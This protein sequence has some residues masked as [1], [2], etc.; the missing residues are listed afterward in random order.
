[1]RSSQ[2]SYSGLLHAAIIVL[3]LPA[4][5]AAQ[6][7]YAAQ[8]EGYLDELEARFVGDG[9]NL[10]GASSGW[11]I[12]GAEGGTLIRL[13][14]GSYVALGA[15]D[16]DCS[17]LELS[18]SG[19]DGETE[20]GADRAADAFPVVEF[21][22]AEAAT[23]LIKVSM[24]GCDTP[25][26]FTGYRWYSGEV[27]GWEEQIALQMRAL[28]TPEDASVTDERTGLVGAG[29]VIRFSLGLEPGNYGG[30]AVCDYDCSDI[31][32]VV[33]GADGATLASDVLE[34]DF[35]IVN[36]GIPEAGT[37]TFEVRMVDCST[38]TCGYGFR[39][40]RQDLD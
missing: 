3:A 26:C 25:R 7:V 5:A 13:P 38:S 16:D 24:P 11:M 36:V 14:A 32:L 30:V 12:P 6:N 17:D 20:L 4:V 9:Y 33:S 21:S 1:M 27:E 23:V 29:E 35:P 8:V 10:E 2:P 19:V 34:D 39:L 40:Y 18:V 31:D 15:C 28:P 37:F 22:L